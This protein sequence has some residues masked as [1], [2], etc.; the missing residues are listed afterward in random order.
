MP[1]TRNP[2]AGTHSRTAQFQR[3][4]ACS[5]GTAEP[6]P[7]SAKPGRLILAL[8]YYK[9]WGRDILDGEALGKDHATQISRFLK[10]NGAQLQFIRRPGRDGQDRADHPGRTLFIAWPNGTE[11][12]ETTTSSQAAEPLQPILERTTIDEPIDLLNLDLST[13]GHTPGATR[14]DSSI[15]LICTHGKRDVCCAVK[16]RPV[17]LSVSQ[18]YDEV[19]ESSHTKGHRFAPSMIMLPS[20]YSYGHLSAIEVAGT[21]EADRAGNLRTTGNRGRGTMDPASQVA[22]LAVYQHLTKTGSALAM[23]QPKLIFDIYRPGEETPAHLAGKIK[24]KGTTTRTVRHR[25]N[26]AQAW[27]VELEQTTVSPV[28]SSCGD[29]PKTATVWVARSVRAA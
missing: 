28:R 16:G 10:A 21:I 20:N 8:E 24:E 9:G 25:T 23:P 11:T 7:G 1:T 13:P 3:D 12:T 15:L 2:R 29:N 18:H 5:S 22:E 26:P 6:L 4:I 27:T 19:W 14:V 17:A